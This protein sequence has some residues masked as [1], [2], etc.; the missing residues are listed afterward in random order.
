MLSG[1]KIREFREGWALR[2]SFGRKVAHWFIRDGAGIAYADC[3][4]NIA[5]FA[6]QLFGVGTWKLC[7]RCSAK[8]SSPDAE[9]LD[10]ARQA[11]ANLIAAVEQMQ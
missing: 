10:Q 5:A 4:P 6:G 9:Y 7:K 3:N 1:G 2:M 11:E 8:H